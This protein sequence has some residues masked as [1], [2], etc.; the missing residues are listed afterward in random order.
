MAPCPSGLRG[1]IANPLFAGS[2][3]AGASCTKALLNR[4]LRYLSAFRRPSSNPPKYRKH[5]PTGQAAVRI[6]GK[7]YYLGPTQNGGKI[8]HSAASEQLVCCLRHLLLVGYIE[9]VGCP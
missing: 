2:N 3:P 8:A 7:D 6:R 4:L 9:A 5:K 1:R